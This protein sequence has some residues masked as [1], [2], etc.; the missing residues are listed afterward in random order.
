[1][2]ALQ[3]VSG[4]AYRA[5]VR[6]HDSHDTL[7]R[8]F[9]QDFGYRGELDNLLRRVAGG[10]VSY[11]VWDG[12]DMSDREVSRGV[13]LWKVRLEPCFTPSILKGA[14]IGTAGNTRPRAGGYR[15]AIAPPA[16]ASSH[17]FFRK[18]HVP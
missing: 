6:I 10:L 15:G 13:Y 3:A 1:M 17:G 12:K 18:R 11:L 9:D 14:G 4:G 16:D 2:S 8:K 5:R 7:V